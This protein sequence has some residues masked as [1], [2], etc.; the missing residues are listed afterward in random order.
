MEDQLDWPGHQP[1]PG[2]STWSA[3]QRISLTADMLLSGQK[4][5]LLGPF[6][7]LGL[8]IIHSTRKGG[9]LWSIWKLSHSTHFLQSPAENF[10]GKFDSRN[11]RKWKTQQTKTTSKFSILISILSW[12][13]CLRTFYHVTIISPRIFL[14]GIVPSASSRW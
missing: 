7:F 2:I 9:L 3:F 10:P 6:H 5:R 8:L 1:F 12:I 14:T 4:T 11:R 13:H